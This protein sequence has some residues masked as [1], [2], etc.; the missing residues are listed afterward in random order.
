MLRKLWQESKERD[1]AARQAGDMIN[2]DDPKA[3]CGHRLKL[4]I[5]RHDL[6]VS[7][8]TDRR[9]LAAGRSLHADVVA[10]ET[11]AALSDIEVRSVLLRGPVIARR[12]YESWEVRPYA[13]VDIL[14]DEQDRARAEAQ[15]QLLG[16]ESSAVL[17][18]RSTDRP[19]WSSTWL[20]SRD[21]AEVDLHWTIVGVRVSS[22]RLW[23]V[24][25]RYIE[26]V[27]VV[28]VDVDGLNDSAVALVVA[29]HVA[30]HGS[31][32]RQPLEDLHRAVARLP[33]ETWRSAAD[34]ATHL[35]ASEALGAG[36]RLVDQGRTLAA[37]LGLP[38]VRTVETLLRSNAAP[39]TALGFDWLSQTPGVRRKMVFI[40]GK[41]VPDREFMRAWSPMA[42]R[43]HTGLVFAYAWRPLWLVWRG[44]PGFRSWLAAR[45]AIRR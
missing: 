20:R 35:N 1:L 4:P 43:G 32:V 16:F 7:G 26:P 29:L 17:G 12:L 9:L 36:L 42:R 6:R 31:E 2:E 39:P 5:Q 27:R 38:P 10:V 19:P 30:H 41:I 25:R 14:I 18:Q 13:D 8:G 11:V 45:R 15:L 37:D 33:F 21:G 28:D 24:F 44:V 23:E 22:V 34:L 40:G 3:S